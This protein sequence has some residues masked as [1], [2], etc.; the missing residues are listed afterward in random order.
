ML[1]W[2]EKAFSLIQ[3]LVSS[4]PS[5]KGVSDIISLLF[6]FAGSTLSRAVAVRAA[7]SQQK[8]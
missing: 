2:L 5:V 7:P 8:W 3:Y 4:L 1:V 6:V